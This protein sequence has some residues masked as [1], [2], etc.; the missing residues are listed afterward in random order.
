M[1]AYKKYYCNQPQ[2]NTTKTNQLAKYFTKILLSIILFLI[3]IIYIKLS[4]ENKQNYENIFFTDSISFTK[5]NDWYQKYFGNVIP[6]QDV[7]TNDMP[8]FNETL[9]YTSI[10]NYL[11]GKQLSVEENYTVPVLESGIIVFLGDKE[12]YGNT[13]IV[14]GNDKIDIWYSNV[15]TSKLTLYDYVKKGNAL[16]QTLSNKLYLIFMKDN[17]FITYEEYFEN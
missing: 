9:N 12:G 16:T 6:I 10:D 3:S 15:D 5:V 7:T 17:N 4:P 11:N 1:D 14:Q 8:V 2:T 13:I